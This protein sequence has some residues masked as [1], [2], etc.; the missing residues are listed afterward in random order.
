M[1]NIME[2]PRGNKH[3]FGSYIWIWTEAL[4]ALTVL[5]RAS[6]THLPEI[7]AVMAFEPFHKDQTDLVLI[8][9]QQCLLEE[10]AKDHCYV[11]KET[12]QARFFPFF[13]I[14][15]SPTAFGKQITNFP[16]VYGKHWMFSF[17]CIMFLDGH[18]VRCL[19][20]L[21]AMG[22]SPRADISSKHLLN[23]IHAG[24]RPR[25]IPLKPRRA[26]GWL[27]ALSVRS[28]WMEH[29]KGMKERSWYRKH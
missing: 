24:S 4:T 9:Q 10:Y 22:I 15:S 18:E 27:E 14:V 26:L 11:N 7:E 16:I 1:A 2:S 29:T 23:V 17:N 19:A 25:Q 5:S 13:Y 6:N 12:S 8:P 28:V 3:N 21:P 20:S